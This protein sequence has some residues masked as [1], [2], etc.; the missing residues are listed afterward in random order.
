MSATRDSDYN[1]GIIEEFRAK[2]GRVGGPWTDTTLILVHHLG[3]KSE[4]ERVTPL[5]C[6]PGGRGPA[7]SLCCTPRLTRASRAT[8]SRQSS[9]GRPSQGSRRRCR[10]AAVLSVCPLL[11][12]RPSRRVA[13][14]VPRDLRGEV[15]TPRS[16]CSRVA[17]AEAV[18]GHPVRSTPGRPTRSLESQR[19]RCRHRSAPSRHLAPASTG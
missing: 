19:A 18:G 14:S 1:S 10:G 16:R 6:F 7:W 9:C 8:A 15:R 11:D 3:A 13:R 12:R 17:G 5:A 2:E 4:V